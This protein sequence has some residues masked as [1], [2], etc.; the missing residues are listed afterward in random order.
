MS[1]DMIIGLD[2]SSILLPLVDIVT[3]MNAA[4]PEAIEM[5]TEYYANLQIML[6]F[7]GNIDNCFLCNFC[8]T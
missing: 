7:L 5:E 3:F 8:M 4:T 2:F 6:F 1:R